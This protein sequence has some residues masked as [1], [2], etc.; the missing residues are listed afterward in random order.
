VG[1]VDGSAFHG[2]PRSMIAAS[3]SVIVSPA[4]AL[5][6]L[7]ISYSTQPNAQMSV[8]LSTARPRACS[9]LM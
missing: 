1:V 6:P 9:G 8:R 3:V 5:R 4:N 7:S 2:G